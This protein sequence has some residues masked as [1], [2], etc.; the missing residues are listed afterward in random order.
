MKKVTFLAAA[1]GLLL[2][3]PVAAQ[4]TQRPAGP[5]AHSGQ[6]GPG[7]GQNGQPQSSGSTSGAT[8]AG[9]ASGK[10]SGAAT[11]SPNTTAGTRSGPGMTSQ[12]GQGRNPIMG[13]TLRGTTSQTGTKTQQKARAVH[14]QKSGTGARHNPTGTNG[15][16]SGTTGSGSSGTSS[17]ANRPP[18]GSN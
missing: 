18:T 9:T 15:S 6:S 11:T 7:K 10:R 14:T 1:L 2:S 4:Q 5:G 16:G 17:G 12:N 13:G 8:G 3:L